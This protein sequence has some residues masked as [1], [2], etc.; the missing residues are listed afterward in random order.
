MKILAIRGKNLASLSAQFEIDFQQEPLLGAGL[1]AITGS[2]GSGKSTI[3]DALCLALYERTP[4]LTRAT[5]RGEAVPDVGD[6]TVTPS[7]PRTILRRGAGEGFAEVD[8]VGSD[9]V[10]YRSRWSVRRARERADGKLQNSV[11]TL[12]R[13]HDGNVLGDRTKTTTLNLIETCIGLSF[14]Q[15]TR[16]V[17]LAQNEFATFLKAPDD[18]RAELLQTLTGTQTFSELSKLAFQR[19]SVETA[20]LKLLRDKLKDEQPLDADAR[21]GLELE[22][23]TAAD[24]KRT[25]EHKKLS[26]EENLRWY[27]RWSLLNE[28][29]NNAQVQLDGAETS[30]QNAAPRHS[31]LLLLEQVQ[32]AGA[33]TA[34]LQRLSQAVD[35]A[36]ASEKEAA[37]AHAVAQSEASTCEITLQ[38]SQRLAN[39]ADVTKSAAQADVDR[40]RALDGSIDALREPVQ[41]AEQ[42]QS[43][44]KNRL[45]SAVTKKHE[46]G[47]SIKASGD[48]LQGA[49]SWLAQNTQWRSL[50]QGWQRWEALFGQGQ[51]L[52]QGQTQKNSELAELELTAASNAESAT[53]AQGQLREATEKSR[54]SA[55]LLTTLANACAAVDADQLASDK[56]LLEDKRDH[57]QEAWALWQRYS[58][59]QTQQ[60]NL[61]QQ[62]E[63]ESQTVAVCVAELAACAQSQP[64]LEG[65]L[66]GAE[67]ALDLAKLAASQGAETLRA[68]LQLD[69]PCPVCGAF[70]HPYATHSPVVDGLLKSMQVRVNVV[71]DA[72]RVV[73]DQVAQD[74]AKKATAETSLKNLLKQIVEFE[75]KQ[76][77]IDSDWAALAV[78][79]PV[80]RSEIDALPESQ[81]EEW[82]QSGL[83]EARDSLTRMA[84]SEATHRDN[85]RRR[86][87]AQGALNV[88]NTALNKAKD[89]L[90]QLQEQSTRANQAIASA[91]EYLTDM[92]EQLERIEGQLDAAFTANDEGSEKAA[93]HV[94]GTWREDWRASPETFVVHCHQNALS[95]TQKQELATS[96]QRNIEDLQFQLSSADQTMNLATEQFEAQKATCAA[97]NFDLQGFLQARSQLFEGRSLAQVEAAL[98]T[99]ITNAR[100]ALDSA[101]V[102]AQVA[103]IT[104]TRC[105][106]AARQSKQQLAQEQQA[107]GNTQTALDEW[108]LE[109]NQRTRQASGAP[110]LVLAELQNLLGTTQAD[111]A[112]E[113]KFLQDLKSQVSASQA[114]LATRRQSLSDHESLKAASGSAEA[115]QAELQVTADDLDKETAKVTTASMAIARD[116]ERSLASA[117]LV[118]ELGRQEEVTLVWLQLGDL[119]GSADGKKF[120]NFAQQLTLD[121]LLGYGNRH[122]QSLSSRYRVLRVKNS[123]GLLVVDQ[124]MGDEVR[125]VHSLSGGESFLVSL[126]MAL[127]LASLSSHRVKVESLFIDEGFGS[128][129]ADSLRVAMDALDSLQAQGRKVGVISHVQE[130]TE[131]IGTRVQVQ[132]EAGGL[133]R[134]VVH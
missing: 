106:E 45:S 84:A 40:A 20:E 101:R 79:A 133:S 1:F 51:T 15:F 63:T 96:C 67:L 9:G 3:L 104:V 21:T 37:A 16:A 111:I 126:A 91:K 13:I 25:L 77:N 27:L 65:E 92:T 30:D 85:V 118:E 87:S 41:A 129:D 17:L 46:V 64:R 39:A 70:D 33:L 11:V 73:L 62:Q 78:R 123:L 132:R 68:K 127:G 97:V 52:L 8:F 108:L 44:A 128:L 5:T 31:K 131:R 59:A 89:A 29:R 112:K 7:D 49:Q 98:N 80:L 71:K 4:R 122:L 32:P 36:L 55:E 56:R 47:V 83:R 26:I 113:R 114:V 24:K 69:Q 124:D 81:R 12:T 94:S 76:F 130:M 38:E 28:E 134:I 14:D 35:Q 99:A 119:I 10:S 105:E 102:K 110:D 19:M 48:Q 121:I 74:T 22:R 42:A 90:A 115:L 54:V 75:S 66:H 18:E 72:L 95:W 88:D 2:T 125:S 82:L 116:G 53:A 57:L 100:S 6:E 103:Q 50:A 34:E 120:R 107:L 109:F 23:Q 86:D 60:Q 43:D 58:D 117:S 61:A 93:D